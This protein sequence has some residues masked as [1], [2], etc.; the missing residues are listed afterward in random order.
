MKIDMTAAAVTI[1]LKQVAQLRRACLALSRSS[2]GLDIQ[3]KTAAN[4]SV[5]QTPLTAGRK[6]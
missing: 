6:L 3:R 4:K 2:T 5:K 1:R